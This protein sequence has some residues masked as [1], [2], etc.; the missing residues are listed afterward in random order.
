[1]PSHRL[2]SDYE[3]VTPLRRAPLH[4]EEAWDDAPPSGTRDDDGGL[5]FNVDADT[6]RLSSA[7]H[8]SDGQ[9][10][11][12]HTFTRTARR[13]QDAGAKQTGRA[14]KP[15]LESWSTRRGHLLGFLGLFLFTFI[16]YYRPYEQVSALASFTSMA[17][18]TAMLTLAFYFP[19]QLSLEGTLTARPLEVNLLL[20]FVLTALLSI[21]LALNRGEAWD[22]FVEPFSKAALMFLVIVNTVRTM[23][24]LRWMLLLGIS[25]GCV[26]SAVALND[27]RHGLFTVEG[28]RVTGSIGNLFGNPN[29][30]AIHLVTVIPVVVAFM[31]GARGPKRLVYAFCLFLLVGGMMVTFSRGGFLGLAGG[32]VVLA[33]KLGRRNR[34]AV[35]GVM[36][37]AVVLMVLLAPGGYSTR[38]LSIF[39]S[40]LDPVGSSSAR[41][42]LLFLSARTALLHPLFGVGM[43]NFHII[44]IREAVTHNSYTQVASEM[45]MAALVIY[46]LFIITPLRRLKRIERATLESRRAS[47]FY[48]LAVGMQASLVA[49]MIGSF[50]GAIAYQWYVYYLVGYAVALRRIYAT[51]GEVKEVGA[52]A[53]EEKVK[54]NAADVFVETK[55]TDDNLI[56]T[57]TNDNPV[58]TKTAGDVIETKAGGETTLRPPGSAGSGVVLYDAQSAR[59]VAV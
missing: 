40:S 35:L 4:R 18:W 36:L 32:A 5:D 16:L 15:W 2:T 52:A 51:T 33:W 30:M 26:L 11:D 9:T 14:K 34:F 27:Y 47:S 19:T 38:L 54:T 57:N 45:G 13:S 41:Q 28:Y 43:G 10:S 7:D 6:E 56:G 20:L 29:D 50:F 42:Q 17:F 23:R 44:S 58:E 39:D 49:Y 8:T 31:F 12:E 1:M 3:P 55:T 24:R 59:V 25:V 46:T 53:L 37:V 22:T 21:P 48:Y